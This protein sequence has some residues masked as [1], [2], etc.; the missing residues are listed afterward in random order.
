MKITLEPGTSTTMGMR[1]FDRVYARSTPGTVSISLLTNASVKISAFLQGRPSSM[2]VTQALAEGPM[3]LLGSAQLLGAAQWQDIA[4]HY[5]SPRAAR[6][7]KS[8]RILFEISAPVACAV[9][10]EF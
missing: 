7:F 2:G 4:F 9:C 6:N 1:K 3:Q 8:V 10:W 5:N